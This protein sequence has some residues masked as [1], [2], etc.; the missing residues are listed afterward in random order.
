MSFVMT[1]YVRE[2]TVMAAD[3]RLS[4]NATQQSPGS[5][6]VLQLGVAQSDST[7]KTFLTP[8]NVGISTYG[9]ADVQGVPITG[10]IESFI[11]DV[12]ANGQYEVDEAATKLLEYFRALAGP[13]VTWFHVAGYKVVNGIPEQQVW[14]VSVGD[15]TRTRV[16]PPGEQGAAWG[17]ESDILMRILQQT[18]TQD[19]QGNY[20]PLPYHQIPW[21]F[22]TLQDAI[23]FAIYAVRT[24][25]DTMR[26]Q[27]RPKTVGGPIDV[28]VIKPT[29]A[30]WV[31]RKE[32][33][34]GSPA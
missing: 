8:Q 19:N 3:S 16:N 21:N 29:E 9:A 30:S 4:L 20:Q 6:P 7:L 2:G 15:D 31:Q 22:F 28:L 17:G 34:G 23:D 10:F 18:A 13:P 32:L 26:F 24:T 33:H 5:Q 25:I 12:L 1:L 27:P 14:V 11:N